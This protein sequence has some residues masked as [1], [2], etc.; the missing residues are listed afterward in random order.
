MEQSDVERIV[1]RKLADAGW[2]DGCPWS[3]VDAAKI[4][5]ISDLP[6]GAFK[7]VHLTW[8]AFDSVGKVVGKAVA[9]GLFVALLAII[10]LGG[11][12]IY[13]LFGLFGAFNK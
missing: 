6:H 11:A 1:E 9:V 13:K 2:H 7:M 8:N 3:K 5:M 10:F 12:T 4:K